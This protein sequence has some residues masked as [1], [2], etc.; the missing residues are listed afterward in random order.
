M[1]GQNL[2]DHSFFRPGQRL[3]WQAKGR[4]QKST[5]QKPTTVSASMISR[6]PKEKPVNSVQV[7]SIPNDLQQ[8]VGPFGS[9]CGN[10]QINKQFVQAGRLK[11]H[12]KECEEITSN[13][14][15][16]DIEQGYVIAFTSVPIESFQP[17]QPNLEKH[18]EIALN[19]L[20]EE[21]L[22]K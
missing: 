18:E 10:T 3:R 7:R 11:F 17:K 9:Q 21:L 4:I 8:S 16:L 19:A 1:E 13:K 14:F 12:L 6:K 15:I 5:T 22:Q 2:E 20:L